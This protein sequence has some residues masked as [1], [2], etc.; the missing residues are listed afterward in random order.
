MRW[1]LATWTVKFEYLWLIE[2][3]DEHLPLATQKTL[4]RNVVLL[5]KTVSKCNVQFEMYCII[6]QKSY[7]H[8][9]AMHACM[10]V[11]RTNKLK[12][13]Y[14]YCCSLTLTFSLSHTLTLTQTLTQT[15]THT[16]TL[17]LT[18]TYTHNTNRK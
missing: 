12:F 13:V 3:Q 4:L 7:M 2:Y 16:L 11:C 10:Y 5:R 1:L 6:V 18:H 17:T 9:L 8:I 14:I 15:L